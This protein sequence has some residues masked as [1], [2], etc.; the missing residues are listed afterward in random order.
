MEEAL[1]AILDE[2]AARAQEEERLAEVAA[3]QGS[4]EGSDAVDEAGQA[5]SGESRGVFVSVAMQAIAMHSMC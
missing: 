1:A 4:N 3:A 5:S 2:A